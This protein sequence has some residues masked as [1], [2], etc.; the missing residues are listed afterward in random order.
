MH[1]QRLPLLKTPARAGRR[2]AKAADALRRRPLPRTRVAPPARLRYAARVAAD[3]S[4]AP[5][6]VM[7]RTKRAIQREC[8]IAFTFQP[9]HPFSRCRLP[10]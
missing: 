10:S 3:R 6:A 2:Q 1:G 4:Q 5:L 8:A 7:K 9:L